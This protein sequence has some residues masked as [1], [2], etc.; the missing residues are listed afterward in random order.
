MSVIV[1]DAE[2]KLP[3][4][5]KHVKVLAGPGAGKTR[6]LVGHIRHVLQ[7]S[8]RLQAT[9]KI[10]CITYTNVGVE[11]IL[12]RLGN[13]ADRVEV[14]TIHSFLYSHVIK[15]YVHLLAADYGLDA[16]KIDGH[17]D[18]I[19]SGYKF[20]DAWKKDSG[21]VYFSVDD[22]PKIVFAWKELR[23]KFD[24]SGKLYLETKYPIKIGNYYVKK[25]SYRLF[26]RMMWAEGWLHHDDVLFFSWELLSR[27]SFLATVLRAKFP[28]YFVDEFQDTNPIQVKIIEL[29]SREEMTIAVIGDAAQSI[30][31]FLGADHGQLERF[32]MPDMVQY[33]IEGNHR[34]T[35]QIVRLL[36]SLRSDLQQT[37]MKGIEGDVV[38]LLVGDKLAAVTYT[39][40]QLGGEPFYCLSRDNITINKVKKG[41]ST[42]APVRYLI[43]QLEAA[44]KNNTDRHRS[45]IAV[46]KAV[47]YARTG[48]FKDALK[49]LRSF[50]A[51]RTLPENQKKKAALLLLKTLLDKAPA[52][53]NGTIAELVQFL[54][55]EKLCVVSKLS[56]GAAAS[57]YTATLYKDLSV[58]VKDLEESGMYRT[59]HKAKGEEFDNVL[60]L[61]DR[62]E[63]GTFNEKKELAFL[64]SPDLNNDDEHRIKYVGLTRAK[65]RLFV[66]VPALSVEASAAMRDFGLEVIALT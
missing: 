45:V 16:L 35:V 59:I 50:V 24:A 38:R 25:E 1:I 13:G 55:D 62:E 23:W 60:L 51:I 63:N 34:S 26:K 42:T 43:E 4:I 49:A 22:H 37:A 15:P 30:Y 32:V 28:Y 66:A 12:T 61:I 48:L 29:L 40:A 64:Q 57:F 18:T 9:R 31:E 19:P 8:R 5:D 65:Q 44:D 6:W 41:I 47:E 20:I 11:T 2:T 58:A 46:V 3:C 52:F 39:R 10:A 14:S 33:R 54:L 27:Y 36:N 7:T 17:D 53:E 21:Q 56:K